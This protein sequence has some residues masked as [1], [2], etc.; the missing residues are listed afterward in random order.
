[1]GS[2][3]QII[4]KARGEGREVLT[5]MESKEL[6]KGLGIPTTEMRLAVSEQEAVAAGAEIGYPCVLKVSSQDISHK[7]DA[8]GV[9]L[10]LKSAE[11]VAAAYQAI[12]ASCRAKYPDA[13][14]EG[15]TVQNMAKPGV[16][17][18]FKIVP[19]TRRDAA[20]AIND[21]R[22]ARLLEGFRGSDPVDKGALE[23]ILLRVSEFVAKT[24]EVAEMDLNPIF[25]Y[26]DGAVAVDAR[27]I[28]GA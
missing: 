27:V 6:L 20:S 23:D 13:A 21:I 10:G 8:G 25:A 2:P 3:D 11:E 16:E 22:A 7:S 4:E 9:K 1:M 24:P 18:S 15:V 12:M 14:I 28:L 19:L 5:E 17:V 26:A